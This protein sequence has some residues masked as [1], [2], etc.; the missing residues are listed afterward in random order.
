MK[1]RKKLPA[2]L[3]AAVMLL[4]IVLPASAAGEGDSPY[5]PEEMNIRIASGAALL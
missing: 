2:V 3:L 1:I 5:V 4:A